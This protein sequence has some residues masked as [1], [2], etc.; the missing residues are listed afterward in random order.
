MRSNYYASINSRGALPR[1]PS[2]PPGNRGACAHVVSHGGGVFAIL[3]QPPE[4]DISIV[5]HENAESVNDLISIPRGDPRL[6]DTR[7][8]ER[9]ISLSGRTRPFV[10]HWLV[11]QGQKKI[12]DVF[13][14]MFSQF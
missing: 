7:V 2:P 4:L 3:S 1:P 6:F 10:K 12:V 8:F 5:K 9:Q 11:H 13:K 14:G